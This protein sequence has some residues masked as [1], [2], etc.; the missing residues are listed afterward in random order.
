M[1]QNLKSQIENVVEIYKSG[2]L[3]EAFLLTEKLIES[4]KKI[5]FLYNLMGL[6]LMAQ[7][8]F[9]ES[10][11]YFEK[12][13]KIDPKF[14]IIYSNLGLLHFSNKSEENLIKAE[15]YYKK[16]IS[17]NEKL[18]ETYNNLGNLYNY[19]NNHE[20]SIS[21][22]K[23]AIILNPKSPQAHYNL[24][25]IYISIGNIDEAKRSLQESINLYP[26]FYHAH[27]SLSRIIKYSK[28][29][30]H[31]E[32]LKK[33]YNNFKDNNNEGKI[34]ISF[35]LGKAS[36]DLK[37]YNDA[38]SYYK[39]A[40]Y[41]YR[42]RINFSI[43]NEE[44][45]FN[46]IKKNFNKELF[47][48]FEGS[49]SN[50]KTPIFIVGMPRSGTTLVEQILS[51]HSKIFGGDE[52]EFI[53]ELLNKNFGDYDSDKFYKNLENASLSNIRKIGDDYI[54]K[55]NSLSGNKEFTTDKLPINFI[56]IGFIKLI[57]P[58][59]KIIHCTRN[60]KDNIL[61]I[62]KNHFPGGQINFAYDI[63]E[64]IEYYNLYYD[65][66]NFW[67]KELPNFIYNIKYDEII[68]DTKNKILQIL[69][70]CNLKWEDNCLNFYKNKRSIKT[71]SDI[72]VRSKIY[73]TSINSWKN[74][75]KFFNE[76]FDKLKY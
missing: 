58:N 53:P 12:G 26:N 1:M 14:A 75:G 36:D 18:P 48:K 42:K 62:Y 29:D 11:L 52:V 60:P 28:N 20:E 35:A 7:Q 2:N 71:A 24:A 22:Y 51:S 40:N 23:K 66:M 47:R 41:L 45:K 30:K 70:F 49:S 44:L 8:K 16:A 3:K 38:Y 55:M 15:N 27:R 73:K 19:L 69:N 9:K 67:N 61:S 43:K 4:N 17:I 50:K 31:Y 68:N 56:S 39:E 72:Q 6:I 33:L 76:Q 64:I 59:S 10:Q 46:I 34:I 21:C 5:V 63:D 13:L 57:L 54:N 65:L 25:N 74:Y 37:N 32:I